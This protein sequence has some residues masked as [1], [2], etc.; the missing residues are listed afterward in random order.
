MYGTVNLLINV[1]KGM[2]IVTENRN[3]VKYK[4]VTVSITRTCLSN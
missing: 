4:Q 3:P 2:K 1:L